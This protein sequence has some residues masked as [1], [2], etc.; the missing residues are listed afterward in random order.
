[1]SGGG[2]RRVE[3][4]EHDAYE[5]PNIATRNA[6]I[7]RFFAKRH[8]LLNIAEFQQAMQSKFGRLY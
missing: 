7:A 4:I 5:R 8:I 6:G 2:E 3:D 1:M